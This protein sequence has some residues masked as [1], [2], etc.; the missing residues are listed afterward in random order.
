MTQFYIVE[1]KEITPGNFEHKVHFAYDEDKDKAER[2]GESQFFEIRSK[3]AVSN[4]YKHSAIMFDS[5]CFPKLNFKYENPL[6]EPEPEPAPE[7][8]QTEEA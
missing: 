1:I 5:E 3:A 8:E 4:C 6:P 7:T 2:K